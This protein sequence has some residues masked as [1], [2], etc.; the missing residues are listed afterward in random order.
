MTT[1]VAQYL[2]MSTDQQHH[3]LR[4]QTETIAA[5]ARNNDFE[6]VQTYSDEGRSGVVSRRRPG[7]M[8]LLRDVVSGDAAYRSILVYDVTRWGRF[9][10]CDEAAHYEF[11]CKSAGI[12]VHYCAEDFVN[13]NSLPNSIVKAVKR[14]MAAEYSREMGVRCFAGSKRLAEL[15]FKQ[16]GA[17]GYGFRRMMISS[18]GQR[19]GILSTGEIKSLKTDRVIL[20]PGSKEEVECVREI[21]RLVL[22]EDRTPFYITKELNSRRISCRGGKWGIATVQRILTDPKYA[23]CNVWNRVT[24]RLG[25]AQLSLPRSQ[26][27]IRPGAFEPLVTPEVFQKVQQILA[28][29]KRGQTNEELLRSLRDLRKTHGALSY[30][31][32][33]TSPQAPSPTTIVRRF[34]TLRRAFELAGQKLELATFLDPEQEGQVRRLQQELLEKLVSL[35]P[36]EISVVKPDSE[37][38]E[39]IEIDGHLRLLV[40]VCP[41]IRRS[42]KFDW[43]VN[44]SYA[45]HELPVLLVRLTTNNREIRDL[46]LV[47]SFGRRWLRHRG[48]LRAGKQLLDLSRF[49]SEVRII[50]KHD[51]QYRTGHVPGIEGQ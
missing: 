37:R 34:G 36:H 43:L 44:L 46:Y 11:I 31:L 7:L 47:P 51:G 41:V 28:L 26:W 12:S 13:D 20:V 30:V 18:D 27:V 49:C 42:G 33:K 15:G 35:F 9:Q 8:R 3:S 4:H 38:T 45:E 23:G 29:Q 25:T 10:D 50:M 39:C 17:P 32:I 5:Y 16:G 22:G 14:T 19:K 48:E 1:P 6:I 24:K 2:R 21:Y 40:V